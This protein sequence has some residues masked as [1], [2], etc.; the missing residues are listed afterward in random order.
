[1]NKL[2]KIISTDENIA[3]IFLRI[4]IAVMLFPHGVQ[5]I[6]AFSDMIDILGNG[7]GLPGFIA[8]LV[9][10]IEFLA[11][12]I[13]IIGAGTRLG[14]LLIAIIML[15][16]I[17]YHIQN[18]FFINWFGNQAGEGYQFHILAVGAALALA[19]LGG[20]RFSVDGMLSKKL[21]STSD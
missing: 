21:T 20:G 2:I 13:I 17:P 7:Y 15:G 6:T 10:L 12:L 8:V 1:M 3:S 4:S 18:G 16:A 11:P 9:I 5:K 14:A 19:V